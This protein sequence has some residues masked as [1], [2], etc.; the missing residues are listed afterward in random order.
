MIDYISIF[1]QYKGKKIPKGLI[2][3]IPKGFQRI[4]VLK[5]IMDNCID[6]K[7]GPFVW[8]WNWEEENYIFNYFSSEI[9]NKWFLRFIKE[10]TNYILRE[11]TEEEPYP[12][13]LL[14]R[15]GN[16]Y[17]LEIQ[18]YEVFKFCRIKFKLKMED[19]REYLRF[20]QDKGLYC[21]SLEYL[22]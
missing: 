2:S 14:M 4:F 13:T 17:I 10:Q 12:Q 19:L 5:Y 7:N 15:E 11:N 20:F 18:T 21:Q 9:L 6:E 3:Q 22:P 16:E 1:Q 8:Y